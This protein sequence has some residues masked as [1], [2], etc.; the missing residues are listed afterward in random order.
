MKSLKSRLAL[1]AALL[2]AGV[3]GANAADLPQMSVTDPDYIAHSALRVVTQPESPQ[4]ERFENEMQKMSAPSYT[5][6][7]HP[8]AKPAP[9]STL[10]SVFDDPMNDSSLG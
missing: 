7:E 5:P 6:S 2:A 1:A 4:F 9:K 3:A 8:D 10:R